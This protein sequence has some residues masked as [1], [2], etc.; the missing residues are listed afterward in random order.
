MNVLPMRNHLAKSG[1]KYSL[2][3]PLNISS[4]IILRVY[5]K[6]AEFIVT[7]IFFRIF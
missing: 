3:Y 6:D 4:E 2:G 5:Y 1:Q 7:D